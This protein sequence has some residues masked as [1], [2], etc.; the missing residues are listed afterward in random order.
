MKGQPTFTLSFKTNTAISSDIF[1]LDPGLGW[2]GL[3][4][5]LGWFGAY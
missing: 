1:M 2:L 5:P 3:P 4:G